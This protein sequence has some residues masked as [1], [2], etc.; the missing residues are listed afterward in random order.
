MGAYCSPNS[1]YKYLK[2]AGNDIVSI[3]KRGYCY[4]IRIKEP[5]YKNFVIDQINCCEISNQACIPQSKKRVEYLFQKSAKHYPAFFSKDFSIKFL[6]NSANWKD[7][8]DLR[9]ESFHI[10]P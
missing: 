9:K 10:N 5:K 2:E 8:E 1:L 3:G 4:V 7:K 6:D